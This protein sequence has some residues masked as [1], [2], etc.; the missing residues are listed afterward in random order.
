MADTKT[1]L[2]VE[3]ELDERTW[4]TAFFADNGYGTDTAVDG[5]EGF[6]KARSGGIDLITLDITMDNQS[7]VRMFKNLQ[8]T[9]ETAGI[10]VIMVT[11]V[12]AEFRS[13]I[14]RTKQVENPEGYFEKPVDRDELLAKVRELIG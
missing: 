7:G 14:E 12:A 8:Q 2:V 9:P 10:P 11:G 3:D 6:A 4:M 13:F 1:I 5:E